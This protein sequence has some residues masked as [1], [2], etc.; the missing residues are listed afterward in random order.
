M[1]WYFISS[2]GPLNGSPLQIPPSCI[3]NS[4][5]KKGRKSTLYIR[6]IRP[7]F[8][9]FAKNNNNSNSQSTTVLPARSF[10]PIDPTYRPHPPFR[11][12][13]PLPSKLMP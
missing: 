8:F 12:S 1:N 7:N 10:R 13:T 5:I 3:A 2:N 11:L 9:G 4:K 6:N